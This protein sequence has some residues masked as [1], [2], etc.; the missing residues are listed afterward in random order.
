M[1]V[2]SDTKLLAS[3]DLIE[4]LGSGIWRG[5]NLKRYGNDPVMKKSNV[6]QVIH[7]VRE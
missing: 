5:E 1:V 7:P 6:V 2:V 3:L 4:S